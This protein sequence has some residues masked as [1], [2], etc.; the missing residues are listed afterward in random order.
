MVCKAKHSQSLELLYNDMNE[1]MLLGLEEQYLWRRRGKGW[2]DHLW[3]MFKWQRRNLLV[4][5]SLSWLKGEITSYLIRDSLK[6]QSDD[7]QR[8]LGFFFCCKS[9]FCSFYSCFSN[10][11]NET[12]EW[13][14]LVCLSFSLNLNITFEYFSWASFP[15]L[16]LHRLAFFV[17]PFLLLWLPSCLSH[18]TKMEAKSNMGPRAKQVHNFL[19]FFPYSSEGPFSSKNMLVW[20][21][22]S[23]TRERE[24]W[25]GEEKWDERERERERALACCP[26][27]RHILKD[28]NLTPNSLLVQWPSSK[29]PPG[30]SLCILPR[31]FWSSLS[32]F[33]SSSS[34]SFSSSSPSIFPVSRKGAFSVLWVLSECWAACRKLVSHCG[35]PGHRNPSA[36]VFFFILKEQFPHGELSKSQQMLTWKLE[37]VCHGF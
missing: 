28:E 6:P 37:T 3:L 24:I 34:L 21:L 32:F 19:C 17:L 31:A 7:G 20:P 33:P 13:L 22:P 15:N 14:D 8:N 2:S 10:F 26:W 27:Q 9:V 25:E 16:Q 5:E 1:A 18:F 4:A 36:Q 12:T 23:V 30:A 35:C 29:I 11:L